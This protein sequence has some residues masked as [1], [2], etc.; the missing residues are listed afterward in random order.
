MDLLKAALL[1]I[2]KVP[3]LGFGNVQGPVVTVTR[4]YWHLRD[5]LPDVISRHGGGIGKR[6]GPTNRSG[7]CVTL[8][9]IV[10][11]MRLANFLADRL[12]PPSL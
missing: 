1:S 6:Y 9:V 11:P 2:S 7:A 5:V 10:G 12:A 3:I 8:A 4:R